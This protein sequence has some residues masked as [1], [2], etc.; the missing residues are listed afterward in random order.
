M[1]IIRIKKFTK[2]KILPNSAVM[3]PKTTNGIFF[4]PQKMSQ[5]D[6][7][8]TLMSNVSGMTPIAVSRVNGF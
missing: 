7:Q 8:S 2:K 4:P 3:N 5:S 1:Q 6:L